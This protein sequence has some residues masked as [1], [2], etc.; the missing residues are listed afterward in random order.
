MEQENMTNPDLI[1]LLDEVEESKKDWPHGT[2]NFAYK[3]PFKRYS[4]SVDALVEAA[5]A[6]RKELERVGELEEAFDKYG[7][8]TKE[9]ASRT[10]RPIYSTDVTDFYPE[11]DCGLSKYVPVIRDLLNQQDTVKECDHMLGVIE[12]KAEEENGEPAGT[13]YGLVHQSDMAI[14]THLFYFCP[15]CGMKL[16]AMIAVNKEKEE[17]E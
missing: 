6:L 15:V 14:P 8:H 2:V 10:F 9:C 11:C 16:E 5:L 12:W 1:A 3:G 13:A 17:T 4:E 7:Q